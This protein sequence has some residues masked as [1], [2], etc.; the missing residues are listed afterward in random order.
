MALGFAYKGDF[1]GNDLEVDACPLSGFY[2]GRRA[3]SPI[4]VSVEQ[5]HAAYVVPNL[6]VRHQ[7]A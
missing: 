1:A 6:W 2:R 7:L 3:L 5:D 4:H